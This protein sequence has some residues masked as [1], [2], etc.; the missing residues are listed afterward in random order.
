MSKISIIVPVHNTE[1]YLQECL[2]SIAAQTISDLEVICID[3]GS[4]DRS[5]DII[6]QYS[7]RDDRFRVFSHPEALGPGA[8]RNK[9][10][11]LASGDYIGFV[12]SD[13]YIHPRMYEDLLSAFRV[14]AEIDFTICGIEKFSESGS[15]KFA[16]GEQ[17]SLLSAFTGRAVNW[18]MFGDRIFDLRFGCCNRLYKKE[19]LVSSGAR[20]SEGIFYE[21]LIFHFKVFTQARSFS[22]IKYAHYKNRRQRRGATTFEQG[23]RVVGLVTAL[24]QLD[25]YLQSARKLDVLQEKFVYFSYKKMREHFHKC[26]FSSMPVMYEYMQYVARD[27]LRDDN[28]F[29]TDADRE[30]LHVVRDSTFQDYLAWDYWQSKTNVSKLKRR[31]R[32]AQQRNQKLTLKSNSIRAVLGSMSSATLRREKLFIWRVFRKLGLPV[33]IVRND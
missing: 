27:R 31:V 7:E 10:I 30:V 4:D 18:A 16:K 17:E 26:D 24:S 25:E 9:G 6:R 5:G 28:R 19:F 2:D 32:A 29:V 14:G 11:E 33:V 15:E 12:D 23:G 21:D 20:F 3:D 22:G 8:A 13:D 1:D